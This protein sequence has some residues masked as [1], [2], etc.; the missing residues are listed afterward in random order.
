MKRVKKVLIIVLIVIFMSVNY[1]IAR[2]INV[3]QFDD[4]DY[5]YVGASSRI[6]GS[7]INF[8]KI[9]AVAISAMIIVVNVF[10]RYSYK[11]ELAELTKKKYNPEDN[12]EED[13]ETKIKDVEKKYKKSKSSTV[14]S[15]IAV[16]TLLGMAGILNTIQTFKPIIYL[17][18]EQEQEVIVE[19]GNPALLTTTYPKY[20]NSWNVLAKPNGD[21]VDLKTGRSL[22]ALYWEANKLIADKSFKEGWCIKGEDSAEFLEEKLAKLGLNEREAEEFIVYW[23]PQLQS[24]KYNLIKFETQEQIDYNM[25]LNITPKPDTIIRIVMDYKGVNSYKEIPAQEIVT[26]ERSGF[27]VVEWGGSKF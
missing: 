18:P 1:S 11:T 15:I 22:Y 12:Q 19:L 5:T 10:Y 8:F 16:F 20:E 9:F 21:L 26:P 24:N 17:Y 7:L 4:V 27:T 13:I 3:G 23:L 25:P 14:S 6:L 2:E